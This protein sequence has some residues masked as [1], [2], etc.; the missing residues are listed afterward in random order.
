QRS[1]EF[2]ESVRI[3]REPRAAHADGRCPRRRQSDPCGRVDHAEQ[4]AAGVRRA[5]TSIADRDR[6]LPP[7]AWWTRGGRAIRAEQREGEG[8]G[9]GAYRATVIQKAKC[10]TRQTARGPISARARLAEPCSPPALT[11]RRSPD[12]R[13]SPRRPHPSGSASFG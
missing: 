9:G 2:V 11:L 3:R 4:T 10:I 8:A 7:A 1:P 12:W 5:V 13:D 6:A